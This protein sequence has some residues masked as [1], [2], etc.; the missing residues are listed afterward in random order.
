M[1]GA[2]G[3]NINPHSPTNT[4]KTKGR[5]IEYGKRKKNAI[6]RL[7]TLAHI[8][9]LKNIDHGDRPRFKATIDDDDITIT[10]P[11]STRMIDTAAIT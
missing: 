10:K 5:N 4:G 6:P 9:C 3:K 2:N 1:F 11:K 8:N 7:P